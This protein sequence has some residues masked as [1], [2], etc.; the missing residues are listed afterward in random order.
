[1]LYTNP[2]EGYPEG[3]LLPTRSNQRYTILKTIQK[4]VTMT[5]WFRAYTIYVLAHTS[6]YLPCTGY[7]NIPCERMIV[8]C[9]T[10]DMYV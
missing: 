9:I 7:W 10:R 2:L 1:M 8:Y 4:N 3:D 6:V 5:L